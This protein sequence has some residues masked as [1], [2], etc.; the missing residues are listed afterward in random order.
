MARHLAARP[1]HPGFEVGHQRRHVRL[2]HGE[3]LLGR[4]AVDGALDVEDGVDPAHG[5]GGQRGARDLGEVKQLATPMGHREAIP[6]RD[7]SEADRAARFGQRPGFAPWTVKVV[8]PRIRVGLQD[9]GVAGQMLVRVLAPAVGRVVEYGSRRF[10]PAERLVVAHVG[11]QATSHRLALRQHG[12]GCV[13]AMDA[14]GR[15]HVR[16]DQRGER[17]KRGRA[18]AHPV[19][20]GRDVDLDAL[21]G[22]RLALPVQRQVLAELGFQDHRQQLGAS[23]AAGDRVERR[24]RL[25]D[26]LARP[27]GEPLPHRLHHLPPPRDHLQ[28]FRDILAQLGQFAPAARALGR[29]GDDHALARQVRRQRPAHRLA[30]AGAR[31]RRQPLLVRTERRLVLGGSRFQL[32]K[33]QL[34]LVQQLAPALGRSAEA[35]VLELGD[36]Q[37]EMRH[38]RLSARRARLRLAPRQP[39]GRKGGTLVQQG[40]AE[41]FDVVR[42]WI[43]GRRHAAD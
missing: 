4:Q 26:R 19:R 8:E 39:L 29:A 41:R 14:L 31:A 10:W 34:Q 9:A 7:V 30:A 38:H 43:N 12:H 37:L 27:A 3:A 35:V 24:R 40:R 28:R 15:H 16:L 33:L 18:R 32:L 25:R 36:Q 2:P 6:R 42:D 22:I 21:A 23:P 17:R 13:V 5:F 1:A 20:H 11:P